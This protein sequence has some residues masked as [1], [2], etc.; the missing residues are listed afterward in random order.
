[1]YIG[2]TEDQ[3]I[4][5]TNALATVLAD[6]YCLY[7]KTQNYH[8]NVVGPKFVQLH[9]IFENQYQEMAEAVDEIAE[10]IRALGRRAPG[11]FHE[12]SGLTSVP[13]TTETLEA[14]QMVADL[15]EGHELMARKTKELFE[16]ATQ[17]GDDVTADLIISRKKVHEKTAWMLRSLL[18]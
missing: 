15:M 9:E 13:E 4:K 16:L 11:S 12:F 3:S 1:M 8:W 17:N 18:Q 5:T 14:D 6:T 7:L 10:R 2:L